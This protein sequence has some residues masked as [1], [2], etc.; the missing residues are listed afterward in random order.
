[1]PSQ[2]RIKARD[3]ML[4]AID[5]LVESY[6]ELRTGRR[7]PDPHNAILQAGVVM[8]CATWELYCESVLVEAANKLVQKVNDPTRLPEAVKRRL[9]LAVHDKE[10]DKSDPLALAADG[11]KLKL[12]ETVG[13]ESRTLNTPKSERIEALFRVNLGLRNLPNSWTH[14]AAEIDDFVTLRGDIAHNGTDASNV[15][16]TQIRHIKS[17]VSKTITDTD[18]AVY[19]YLKRPDI[20]GAAP[21]QR[22]NA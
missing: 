3:K 8:I 18:D 15:S 17:L 1:M 21:W 12:L 9:K 11:W 10:V 14:S 13:A 16:Q 2:A 7:G 22:T 4:P 19:E 6:A 20:T 5:R